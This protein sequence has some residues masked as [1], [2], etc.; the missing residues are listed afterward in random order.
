MSTEHQSCH[1]LKK[2]PGHDDLMLD[3]VKLA[4]CFF[5]HADVF[6]LIHYTG[7]LQNGNY[8]IFDIMKLWYLHLYIF[9]NE[10]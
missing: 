3:K 6:I 9:S 7:F 8:F 10:K 1:Q 4:R 2:Q 5:D